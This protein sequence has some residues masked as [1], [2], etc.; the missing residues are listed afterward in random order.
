M[1][2]YLQFSSSLLWIWALLLPRAYCQTA[3]QFQKFFPAWS[4]TLSFIRDNNCTTQR[5]AYNDSTKIDSGLAYNLANCILSYMPAF[6]GVEM[7]IVSILFGLLPSMM[8]MVGPTPGEVSLLAMRRP[9]LALLLTTPMPSVRFFDDWMHYDHISFL[10]R[11]VDFTF[12]P[13]ILA[14]TPTWLR[15]LLSVFEYTMAG[16][17]VAN[18][19]FQAYQLAFWAVSVSTIAINS[20]SLPETYAPF[21]WI[22]LIVLM[23]LLTFIAMSLRYRKDPEHP[24]VGH[25]PLLRWL[26]DE[27]TPCLYN[28]PLLLVQADNSYLQIFVFYWAGMGVV[29]LFVY[30]TVILSSTIFISLGDAI[31]VMARFFLGSLVC[32]WILLFELHGMKQVTSQYIKSQE[33]NNSAGDK[34]E[35][36][37]G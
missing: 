7:S 23:H 14:K 2:N 20:G 22:L 19:V 30:A 3:S 24:R 33:S 21:L 11:R 36:V 15:A 10:R 17:A 28:D 6:K 9:V 26:N 27:I 18:M 29:V 5:D 32:R 37:T 35:G 1:K 34:A 25:K 31:P 16:V 8:L 13:K 12:Q 4:E